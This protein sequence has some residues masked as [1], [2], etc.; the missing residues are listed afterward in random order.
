MA[1]A[2]HEHVVLNGPTTCPQKL[3]SDNGSEFVNA[4]ADEMCKQFGIKHLRSTPYHPTGNAFVERPHRTYNSIMRTFLHK[5]G[6]EFDETLPY[7]CRALNTHAFDGTT[8]SPYELVFGQKP[9]D[10]NSAALIEK[11]RLWG[12]PATERFQSP[13]ES[14][15]LLRARLDEVRTQLTTARLQVLRRNQSLLRQVQYSHKYHVGDLVLRWTPN[16]GGARQL[17]GKLAYKCTGPYKIVD[18][19][20]RNPDVYR[21][22]PL[23]QPNREPTSHHVRELCPYVTQ[24]AHERQKPAPVG[25]V[26]DDLLKELKVGDHLLLKNGKRDY[27]TLVTKIDGQYVTVQYYNKKKPT[28]GPFKPMENLNLVWCKP[29]DESKH[30]IEV[31]RPTLTPA[32]IDLGYVAYSEKLHVG[33]FYQKRVEE[34]HLTRNAKGVTIPRG[35]LVAVRKLLPTHAPSGEPEE[36]E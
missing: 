14:I 23:G 34:S 36:L 6:K 4:I 27:L 20:P 8:V 1:L 19:N 26:E 33:I 22:V 24:E 10:P 12:K 2:I 7:A 32:Q 11:H 30:P 15:Q 31:Y 13:K 16:P 3:I 25:I 9:I 35:K 18:V 5:Y 21:L 28:K 29:E 17:Y